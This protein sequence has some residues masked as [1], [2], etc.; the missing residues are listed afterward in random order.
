MSEPM[1]RRTSFEELSACSDG[2]D[3]RH[4]LVNGLVV[5]MAPSSQTQ[6]RIAGY[7]IRRRL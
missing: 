6:G 1:P 7:E 4:M 3:S 5:A 2:T